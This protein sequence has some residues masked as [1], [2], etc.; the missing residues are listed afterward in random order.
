MTTELR[1]E[2]EKQYE[3]V[4]DMAKQKTETLLLNQDGCPKEEYLIA[5]RS[6]KKE[7]IEMFKTLPPE[8][9]KY[10]CERESETE[11][12]FSR[13]NNELNH[14][15]WIDDVY[16]SRSERLQ[17][18]GICKA[19]EWVETMAKI[20]D[21]LDRD[22]KS[23][24]HD[25]A[26]I[27]GVSLADNTDFSPLMDK[28]TAIEEKLCNFANLY[29]AHAQENKQIAESKKAKEASFSPKGKNTLAKDLSKL[30]TREVLEMKLA[31]YDD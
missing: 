27:Y 4:A 31:E 17:K 22:A 14:R 23:T 7:Y 24:L 26:L 5:P 6:F 19:Q 25:L 3:R 30:T 20:D 18:Q 29:Q 12:G 16:A 9:R 15:R 13:L 8:M 21:A 28:L 1:K 2:L 10:L 11:R